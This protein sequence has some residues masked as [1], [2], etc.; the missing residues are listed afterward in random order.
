MYEQNKIRQ[1]LLKEW[2]G[3]L[4]DKEYQRKKGSKYFDAKDN[5]IIFL[6]NR[7]LLVI[8]RGLSMQGN[9]IKLNVGTVEVISMVIITQR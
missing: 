6:E 4:K 9:Y 1:E 3:K 7:F 8:Q 2:E 5:M